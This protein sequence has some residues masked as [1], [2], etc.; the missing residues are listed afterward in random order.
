M[1]RSR[2]SLPVD[3]TVSLI[4][5]QH[6]AIGQNQTSDAITGSGKLSMKHAGVIKQN[7]VHS[8][9]RIL[10]FCGGSGCY[11]FELTEINS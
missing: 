4:S 7:G 11:L 3:R 5:M 8:V 1:A 2:L 9:F 6:K 10:Y